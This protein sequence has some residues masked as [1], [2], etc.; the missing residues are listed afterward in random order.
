LPPRPSPSAAE[1][2]ARAGV[3]PTAHLGDAQRGWNRA[4]P[5]A[6]AVQA[7]RIEPATSAQTTRIGPATSVQTTRIGPATS[8]QTTRIGPAT[9][10]EAPLAFE[11]APVDSAGGA[12]T[13]AASGSMWAAR[14]L[15]D[16]DDDLV[17]A[18]IEKTRIGVPAYEAHAMAASE[19]PTASPVDDPALRPAQAVRVVVWR[20]ADGVHL[21]PQGTR[22]A[23][24]SV[25]AI[26]V[27]L[28]PST[29]LAAWLCK[30]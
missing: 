21:A 27:A 11:E 28:D 6:V 4:P 9:A 2:S 29:D 26:L 7:A 10:A 30:K 19:T 5:A 12:S 25:D 24:I 13:P 16:D 3:A 18:D 1:A 22:V 8:V 23:A 17:D 15:L 20:A 14:A